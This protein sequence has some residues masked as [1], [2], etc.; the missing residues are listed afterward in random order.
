MKLEVNIEKKYAFMIGAAILIFAGVMAVYAFSPT[1][2]GGN[3]EVFGHSSGEIR[4]DSNNDGNIDLNDKTLQEY[5][6]D[7][8]LGGGMAFGDWVDMGTSTST[9][10]ATTDGFAV[11]WGN[12]GHCGG[13]I[14]GYTDSDSA[15]LVQMHRSGSGYIDTAQGGS[16][17][18]PV[19]AGDSW[20]IGTT[21]CMSILGIYWMPVG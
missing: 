6:D 16:I 20:K 18:M 2:V 14:F 19:R 10:T 4:V 7:V 3:P 8:G 1:A 13:G 21:G 9:H 17:T 15:S 12:G 11:A 5:I